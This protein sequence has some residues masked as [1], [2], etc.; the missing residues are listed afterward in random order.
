MSPYVSK[1]SRYS[2]RSKGWRTSRPAAPG[3]EHLSRVDSYVI[4]ATSVPPSCMFLCEESHI[5]SAKRDY[6]K[7]ANINICA[8]VRSVLNVVTPS[9][10][11]D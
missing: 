8:C 11:S 6:D 3:R 7:E 2:P 10:Y 1:C 4:A 9:D 5:G